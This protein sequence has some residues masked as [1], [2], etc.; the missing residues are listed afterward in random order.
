VNHQPD[1]LVAEALRAKR[2]RHF[3]TAHELLSRAVA[4]LRQQFDSLALASAL[5]ELGEVERAIHG[6]HAGAD[7]Y[8]E[9]VAILRT[10]DVPLK[11]AHTVRHLGDSYRHAGDYERAE[12]CYDESLALYR[13]EPAAGTL[14][15]ANALRGAALLQELKGNQATALWEQARDLYR[16]AN[17]QAGVD[18]ASRR[19]LG[20]NTPHADPLRRS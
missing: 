1:H 13:R 15:F 20:D 7:V 4:A 19:L 8:E 9:A 6:S 5:R 14:D 16:Q 3:D 10:V 12:R 17:V 2:E 11:L 18:E